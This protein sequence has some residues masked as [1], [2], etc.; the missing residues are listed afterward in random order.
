MNIF[1]SVWQSYD[2]LVLA[3]QNILIYFFKLPIPLAGGLSGA[4]SIG[5]IYVFAKWVWKITT[6]AKK[7]SLG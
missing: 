6:P 3:I 2:K 4:L 5:L 1:E 7:T